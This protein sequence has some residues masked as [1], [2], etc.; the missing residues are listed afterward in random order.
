MFAHENIAEGKE[1]EQGKFNTSKLGIYIQNNCPEV[2]RWFLFLSYANC[3][4]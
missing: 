2:I 3:K 4:K 1:K